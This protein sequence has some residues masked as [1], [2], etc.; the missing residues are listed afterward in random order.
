MSSHTHQT[1][2]FVIQRITSNFSHRN[3]DQTRSYRVTIK[4]RLSVPEHSLIYTAWMFPNSSVL[5]AQEI[6]LHD[7]LASML[8]ELHANLESSIKVY[9]KLSLICPPYASLPYDVQI[10]GLHKSPSLLVNGVSQLRE[11]SHTVIRPL[12]EGDVFRMIV[13]IFERL[14]QKRLV[15]PLTLRRYRD[16]I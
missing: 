1:L 16:E 8:T 11:E 5:I 9:N 15:E 14:R 2:V 7:I 4:I 13:R 6:H 3:V 10:P 12:C